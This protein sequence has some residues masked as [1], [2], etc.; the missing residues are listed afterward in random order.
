MPHLWRLHE[1]EETT[2]NKVKKIAERRLISDTLG[3]RIQNSENVSGKSE[4]NSL[5]F[6][7]NNEFT[8]M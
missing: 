3:K 6:V 8:C 4:V 1:I 7:K 2:L 5:H